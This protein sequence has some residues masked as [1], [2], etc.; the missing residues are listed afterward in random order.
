M[1][2][3]LSSPR[4]PAPDFTL[5]DWLVQ[6]S[7]NRIQRGRETCRLR[8]QLIDLLTCLANSAGRTL[9][10]EEI[11]AVVW[12]GQHVT[13]SGLPRCIAE[14][15]QV[16][17]DTARHEPRYI[18]TIPKR[19]Y[20]L[21]APVGAAADGGRGPLVLA[22]DSLAGGPASDRT[23]RLAFSLRL[24]EIDGRYAI[25]LEGVDCEAG[26]GE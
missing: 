13:D 14:L 4:H 5:G 20:R 19:G 17:G 16:L 25:D 1:H 9:T 24:V 3:Q 26:T 10:K 6:P 8:P 18:E 21:V 7:L 23:F 2:A 22:I 11:L 15:R 12:R